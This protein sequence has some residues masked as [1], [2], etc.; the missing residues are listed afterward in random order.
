MAD[1]DPR[2]K[3]LTVKLVY[4]GP[5][6]SGKTTNL[7]A[8]YD[9][10][11]P[12]DRGDLMMLNT[13]GDRTVFFDLLPVMVEI[14]GG[15]KLKLKLYTVPGQV[16]HD[17]TRK[18]VLSRADGVAFIADSQ[19][20]QA[21]NNYESFTNLEKNANRVGLDFANL[22]LVLQ[23]NK[24][25]LADIIPQSE[26]EARW[27]PTGLPVFFA[28]A[29]QKWGVSETFCGLLRSTLRSLDKQLGLSE[30]YGYKEGNILER[31][32]IGRETRQCGTE[33]EICRS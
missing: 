11:S 4:Y 27:Q 18:A 24:R 22:P 5:A 21:L 23:F 9:A 2:N 29:L 6:L 31:V 13:Q 8:L 16:I 28:S 12:V 14:G 15:V 30:H 19:R 17:A 3:R 26:V 7:M 1:F 10:L 32:A 33:T 20:N 25:D